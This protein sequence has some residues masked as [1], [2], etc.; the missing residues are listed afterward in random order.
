MPY[1]SRKSGAEKHSHLRCHATGAKVQIWELENLCERQL[2]SVSALV[3]SFSRRFGVGVREVVVDAAGNVLLALAAA[4]RLVKDMD[5]FYPLL[6]ALMAIK[7]VSRDSQMDA[8][9]HNAIG[10]LASLRPRI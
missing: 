10:R 1:C 2:A 7:Q 9:Y 6:A 8:R 4:E 3:A 5:L